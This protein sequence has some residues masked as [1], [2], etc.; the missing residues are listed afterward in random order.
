[1]SS[2][3]INYDHAVAQ[4]K[5]WQKELGAEL[6]RQH[7]RDVP[8]TEG[9]PIG[10]ADTI[11]YTADIGGALIQ[12]AV[13]AKNNLWK[14]LILVTERVQRRYR[15]GIGPSHRYYAMRAASDGQGG[16]PNFK[17][18]VTNVLLRASEITAASGATKAKPALSTTDLEAMARNEL[19]GIRIPPEFLLARTANGKYTLHV[20]TLQL[21][22]QDIRKVCGVLIQQ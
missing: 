16:Q 18:A 20:S 4:A 12:L 3:T 2:E 21:T 22:L 17:K 13:E 9:T 11:L 8:M 6:K 10:S 15:T 19:A 7:G 1:M 14:P 5:G